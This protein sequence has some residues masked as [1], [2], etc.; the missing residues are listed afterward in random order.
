MKTLMCP[1]CHERERSLSC[2]G[3]LYRC[4]GPCMREYWQLAKEGKLPPPDPRRGYL[5]RLADWYRPERKI[6][7]I[8]QET[9]SD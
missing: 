5:H 1:R 2:S 3:K 7:E 6:D 4:C 8:S 9:S